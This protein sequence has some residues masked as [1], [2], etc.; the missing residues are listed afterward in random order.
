M[1]PRRALTLIAAA[2]CSLFAQPA[3]SG[4]DFV[5]T[6][7][8]WQAWPVYCRVQYT[9][10]N[11]GI[12]LQDEQYSQADI[13]QWMRALGERT[14]LG[15]HH[16]CASIHFLSRARAQSDPQMRQFVM[17]R[18]LDD[19]IYSYTRTDTMS[20]V[21]PNM[22]IVIAQIK[23][24]Q[25]KPQEAMEVLQHIIKVRPERSEPYVMLAL[26]HRKQGKLTAARDV[27]R[28]AN[29]AAGGQ[30]ADIEY[31]LGL[32]NLELGDIDA[33]VAN[34][35]KVYAEGYPL[36]GLKNKLAAKGRSISISTTT[37]ATR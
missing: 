35:Q 5:P 13:Q 27:L 1:K 2:I 21:Y 3:F 11:D 7:T 10:V 33:A 23:T 28:D 19:A 6:A 36:L 37:D 22:A 18:A 16:Y 24:E 29:T 14:F 31:N 32:I 34:A 9:T 8:E 25:G 12:N 17:N 4:W 15:L 20:P 26:I 30:S